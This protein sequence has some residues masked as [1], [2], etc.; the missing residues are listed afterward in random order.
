MAKRVLMIAYHY[1]PVKGS[2]GVQRTLNF[3]RYL[4]HFGW[5]VAVLT[6]HPRAFEAVGNDLLKDVPA[7]VRVKR[8]FALNTAKHLSLRGAYPRFLALPD[9]WSTWWLG[10]VTSGL[11]IIRR[12][13]PDMLWSTYPI[14]T[15]HLIGLTLNKLTKLP[16]VADFRDPMIEENYPTNPDIR[17]VYQWIERKT[18]A[19]ASRVVVT[20]PGTARRYARRY[21]ELASDKWVTI[22]NGY[23]EESFRAAEALVTRSNASARPLTL[24]HSGILYPSE[25]DP[26]AFFQ[27]LAELRDSGEVTRD[28]LRVTLRATSYDEHYRGVL[29]RMPLDDIVALAPGVPYQEALAEMMSV[30]GLIIFQAANCNDQIPA[31]LYEYLRARRPILALTDRNG[32]T[33]QTLLSHGVD[34]VWPLDDKEA[35]KTGLRRFLSLVREGRAPLATEQA[36]ARYSRRSQTQALAAVFD[37]V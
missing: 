36:V 5:E 2:S 26:T 3:S 16:W 19:A 17:R 37:S 7:E 23:D 12:W 1:P 15:A 10:G 11:G 14:A 34:T 20:T 25:R 31:K 35:I 28:K 22:D 27:A 8:A 9:R 33:A 4:G 6:V 21:A 29:T 30:D 18:V 24:L 13:R 32:D